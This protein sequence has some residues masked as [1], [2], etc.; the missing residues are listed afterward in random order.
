MTNSKPNGHALC[1]LSFTTLENYETNL[2]TLLSLVN[3]A[4]AGSFVLGSE[5]CLS[6]FDYEH[7]DE[8]LSFA[9]HAVEKLL[10]ASKEKTVMLTLVEKHGEDVWNMFKVFHKGSLAYE[11]PKAKLFRFG[12]EEKY[13]SEAPCEDVAIF[14]IEG[15]RCGVL[16][17]FELRFKELWQRL[18]GCDVIF[19]PAWWGA[20]RTEHFITLTRALA[21]MNQCY[22]VLSDAQ[23]EACTQISGVIKPNGEAFYNGKTP[24]L[25]VQYEKKEIALMRRYM[26][27]GIG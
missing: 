14:E 19:V 1:P 20:L 22:V 5:V 10:E 21:I 11:R 9:P 12:G 15:I 13:F 24:S 8:V 3:E 6:G 17:C 27:V 26:D 25:V 16:I 18:E 4:P 2:S 7:W 23:N